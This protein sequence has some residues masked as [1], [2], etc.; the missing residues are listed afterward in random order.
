MNTKKTYNDIQIYISMADMYIAHYEILICKKMRSI[1]GD[2]REKQKR[3]KYSAK[4][5]EY[6]IIVLRALKKHSLKEADKNNVLR[7]R[8]WKRKDEYGNKLYDV[9]GNILKV[10]RYNIV[11]FVRLLY[12]AKYLEKINGETILKDFLS[13]YDV[14]VIMDNIEEDYFKDMEKFMSR[15]SL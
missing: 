10:E 12:A 13:L 4:R 7:I 5:R 2:I 1:E 15:N 8:Y 14:K 6:E 11:A 9:N 3:K